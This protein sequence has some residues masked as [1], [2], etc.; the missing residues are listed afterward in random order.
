[1]KTLWTDSA[2]KEAQPIYQMI[3]EM[4]YIRELGD[5]TLPL[6]KFQQYL[7]QDARYLESFGRSLAILAGLLEKRDHSLNFIRFAEI[8]FVV[9]KDLHDSY[10]EEFGITGSDPM[11]R[12][13]HH[14]CAFIRSTILSEG[15]RMGVAAVLPC[16]WVYAKI[17]P[18]LKRQMTAGNRYTRWIEA[19]CQPDFQK[20]V[21]LALRIANEVA[22]SA[23]SE[24][25]DRMTERFVQGVEF[26]FQFWNWAY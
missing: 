10:F 26:E 20:T 19:Y 24:T 2:W 14:Y 23:T 16:F 3:E 7:G 1:M 17:G 8:A 9:E 4:P 18:Y 21:D 15:A 11:G 12:T 6:E 13:C 22:D 5:G 25:R